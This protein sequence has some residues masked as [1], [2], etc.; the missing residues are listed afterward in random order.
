MG[1][2]CV[3]TRIQVRVYYLEWIVLFDRVYRIYLND[4]RIEDGGHYRYIRYDINAWNPDFQAT[5]RDGEY[6]Q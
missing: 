5:E 1:Q 3:E 4:W 6:T 2:V